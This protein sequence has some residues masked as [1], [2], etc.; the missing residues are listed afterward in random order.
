MRRRTFDSIYPANV[1]TFHQG[2]K[3]GGKKRGRKK[4]ERIEIGKNIV[5]EGREK[6]RREREGRG[7]VKNI[8]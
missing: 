5:S 8:K 7:M 3:K 4:R 2:E 6:G 1:H